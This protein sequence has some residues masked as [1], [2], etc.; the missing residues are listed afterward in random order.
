MAA[1][2]AIKKRMQ[3]GD[4]QIRVV[5]ITLDNSYPAGGWALT[6][7]QLGLGLNGVVWFVLLPELNGF[8]YEWDYVN[9]KLVSKWGGGANAANANYTTA[10][11]AQ[12][13]F[14]VRAMVF[15]TGAG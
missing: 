4:L 1:V 6:P 10:G 14:V 13:G 11:A 15:G 5:D 9:N 3:A 8:S 2:A 7:Q 12:N